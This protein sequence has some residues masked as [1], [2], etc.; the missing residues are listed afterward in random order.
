VGVT[1]LGPRKNTD[2]AERLN[3]FIILAGFNQAMRACLTFSPGFNQAIRALF[4]TLRNHFNG[5]RW[6]R[7]KGNVTGHAVETGSE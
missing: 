5:F 3:F 1:A 7:R 4:S 6:R 2:A